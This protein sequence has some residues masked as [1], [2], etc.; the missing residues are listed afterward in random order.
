MII[1][2]S[3][4]GPLVML[5]FLIKTF[6]RLTAL[7]LWHPATVSRY[8]YTFQTSTTQ[9]GIF[10]CC[11][12]LFSSYLVMAKW[13]VCSL[14]VQQNKYSGSFKCNFNIFTLWYLRSNQMVLCADGAH[15]SSLI[16]SVNG[17]T[18]RKKQIWHLLEVPWPPGGLLF[19]PKAVVCLLH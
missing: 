13:E 4:M 19:F 16:I 11:Y 1:F 18:K 17:K 12:Y 10:A 5:A 3:C 6:H 8:T 15:H 7:S 9:T 2:N 14:S